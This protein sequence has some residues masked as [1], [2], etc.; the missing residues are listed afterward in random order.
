MRI[1]KIGRLGR[2]HKDEVQ[3]RLYLQLLIECHRVLRSMLV[4]TWHRRNRHS[5]LES[6]SARRVSIPLCRTRRASAGDRSAR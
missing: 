1:E 6:L 4:D 3:P 2:C 5:N